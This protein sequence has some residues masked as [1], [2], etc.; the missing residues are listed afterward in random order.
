MYLV[1]MMRAWIQLKEYN[2]ELVSVI[3]K[4][5]MCVQCSI[6]TKNE[7]LVLNQQVAKHVCLCTLFPQKIPKVCL[8]TLLPQKIPKICLKV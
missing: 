1:A 4:T 3:S 8:C 2:K 6:D 7:K 5:Y